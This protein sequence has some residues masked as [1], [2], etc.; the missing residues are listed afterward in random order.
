MAATCANWAA[1]GPSAG[2]NATEA[3][4]GSRVR[5]ACPPRR[6]AVRLASKTAMVFSSLSD[7]AGSRAPVAAVRAS[8]ASLAIFWVSI[9]WRPA[10]LISRA[11][12]R[13][14]RAT[15]QVEANMAAAR[16]TRA[17]VG[18][19]TLTRSDIPS[20]SVIPSS[21]L[22]LN[23]ER[24]WTPAMGEWMFVAWFD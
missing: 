1:S 7:I 16:L 22:S 5:G 23:R 17:R 24:R 20:R 2:G 6:S 14:L 8:S 21:A 12:P 18:K 19:S 15:M 4:D 3:P 10:M 13:W 11:S 9:R